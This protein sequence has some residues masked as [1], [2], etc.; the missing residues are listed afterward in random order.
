MCSKDGLDWIHFD[1]I[2]EINGFQKLIEKHQA[3][4]FIFIGG[5]RKGNKTIWIDTMKLVD[6]D[7]PW[8]ENEPKDGNNCMMLKMK[9]HDYK[10]MSVD[11]AEEVKVSNYFCETS[12]V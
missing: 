4:D 10:I 5:Y 12:Q 6:Y 3:G 1:N 11:C 8:A 2:D 7:I 9:N